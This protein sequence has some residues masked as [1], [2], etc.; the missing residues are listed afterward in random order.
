L[1]IARFE[2]RTTQSYLLN[3]IFTH[4]SARYAFEGVLSGFATDSAI[5]ALPNPN[6]IQF[7]ERNSEAL[8]AAENR[9]F[10]NVGQDDYDA[11]VGE[12]A[13]VQWGAG[14]FGDQGWIRRDRHQL[15][16]NYAYTDGHVEKLKWRQARLDHFPDHRVR[17][18]LAGPP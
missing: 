9:E 11:W 12:S 18:P 15:A 4:K 17:N 1:S 13:L 6:L 5:N 7:S 3:S 16:A 14:Q 10:G 2:H 8:D